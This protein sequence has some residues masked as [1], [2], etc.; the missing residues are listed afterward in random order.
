M[1]CFLLS[2]IEQAL[3]LQKKKEKDL[4]SLACH[5]LRNAIDY[6]HSSKAVILYQKIGCVG[7]KSVL[8]ISHSTSASMP[9]S[10]LPQ[11]LQKDDLHL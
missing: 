9:S 4:S 7:S 11:C 6:P 8:D 2:A 10:D 3:Q 5:T 1:K